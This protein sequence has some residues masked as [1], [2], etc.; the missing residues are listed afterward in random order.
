MKI[1]NGWVKIDICDVWDALDDDGK[2]EFLENIAYKTEVFEEIVDQIVNEITNESV[3]AENFNGYIYKAREKI[4][5]KLNL[6]Q[7]RHFVSLIHELECAKRKAYENDK[8][9][10]DLRR[11]VRDY[12]GFDIVNQFNELEKERVEYPKWLDVEDIKKYFDKEG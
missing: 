1:E 12:L 5:E 2:R 7:A 9:Y 8:K 4:L 10:W 11:K 3:V 6:I